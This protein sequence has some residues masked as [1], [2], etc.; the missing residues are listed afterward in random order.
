MESGSTNLEN[1]KLPTRRTVLGL[2]LG[3][4]AALAGCARSS[5]ADRLTWW[6]MSQ[7]GENAPLLIPAFERATGI[8]VEVQALPWTAAHEKLLTAHAGGSLPDV[9]MVKNSWLA[10]LALVGALAPVPDGSRALLA[11]QFASAVEAATV[12]SK[13]MAVPW[14]VDS[15]V[16]YYRP[17]VLAKAGFSAPP[18]DWAEWTR[19]ARALKQRHPD[20]FAVL[21]LLDWPEPLMAFAAQQ[22]DPMLK[23]RNTRGNF[24]TPGFRAALAFYKG[25]Y[26]QGFSPRVVGSEVG[27]TIVAFRRGWTAI[28]PS[29]AETVGDLRRRASWFPAELWRVAPTPGPSGPASDLANGYSLAVSATTRD[30][31]SAWQLVDYLARPGTQQS[32]YRVTGDL[33]SRPSAWAVLDTDPSAAVLR[34]QVDRGRAA[35]PIAEWERIVSE[36]QLV[37]ERMVRGDFGVI[38][39]TQ[40]MNKRVDRILEKRRWLLDR[41]LLS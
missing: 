29:N 32:L 31:K 40:E 28:L 3:I 36:V 37:A 21:H 22:P 16:Q 8:G 13:A 24:T 10:E 2:G 33:P 15:W 35:P 26:D 9:L 41:G 27:D 5:Q 25:I 6:A 1:D 19:M 38:A 14:V 18:T 17:D 4:G 20:R 23:D 34:G 12:G 7:E 30:P 11:D 39:A